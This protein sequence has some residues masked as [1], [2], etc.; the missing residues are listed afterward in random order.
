MIKKKVCVGMSGGVDSTTTAHLLINEGHEVFGATMYLFDEVLLD[1]SLAPPQFIQDAKVTCEKLGIP[2]YVIDLR[3]EFETL[4]TTP[5]K[6]DF[7]E[8]R[9]PNPCAICNKLVKYGLFMDAVLALGAEAVAMGH[10]VRIEHDSVHQTWHLKKGLTARKDQSFYLHGVSEERLS[11]LILPLG[12]YENKEEVRA[13]ARSFDVAVSD[14]KDSLG[15]CFTSGKTPFEYLKSQ[16]PEGYG[17]GQFVLEDGTAVGLHDG[18]FQFTIG[19]KKG[20]PKLDGRNL[21][22]ICINA[23]QMQ[24]V[25]GDESALYGQSLVLKDM[26][27]I[28]RPLSFPWKGTFRICTWGYD[29]EG[30]IEPNQQDGLWCVKFEEPVRGIAKGQSCVVYQNDEI[31]GGGTIL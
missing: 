23:S 28:H 4:I 9:T 18:Y 17:K 10:Y 8:G 30:T 16:L 21:S 31:L 22:V 19:Q 3:T 2:H 5:F 15:I 11:K 26:N 25:L 6:K 7:I 24:V 1:G 12:Q 13:I 29:L 14:K 20:L 27:W